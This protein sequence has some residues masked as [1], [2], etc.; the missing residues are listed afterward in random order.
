MPDVEM[1]FVPLAATFAVLAVF[2]M[3]LGIRIVP[4]QEGWVVE[5]LG[6]FH[7]VL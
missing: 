3:F 2:I 5:R 7:A 1:T 4:Q 6:R